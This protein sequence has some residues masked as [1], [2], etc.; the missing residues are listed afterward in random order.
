MVSCGGAGRAALPSAVPSPVSCLASSGPNWASACCPSLGTNGSRLV[1]WENFALCRDTNVSVNAQVELRT[2]GDFVTRSNEVETVCLRVDPE[3]WDGDGW[4]NDDDPDP[5]ESEEDD[6]P[7]AAGASVTFSAAAV[8]FESAY[9]NMPGEVVARRS[10]RTTLT[11]VAHGGETGGTASF[12]IVNGDK[13]VTC[14]GGSLPVTRFVP[15]RQKLE[16]EIEYEGLLPSDALGDIV[17]RA[18]FTERETGTRHQ[19]YSNELTSVKF[20]HWISRS[21]NCVIILDGEILQE[22]HPLSMV[23][24]SLSSWFWS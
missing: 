7:H 14:A 16:F 2:M 4:Q 6:G 1:T 17:A 13:L 8:I 3:D 12:S 24:Q 11:C 23:R 22:E 18:D 15:P 21:R 10:T 20:G 19:T 5:Y 9:T